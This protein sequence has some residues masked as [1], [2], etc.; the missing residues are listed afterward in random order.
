MRFRRKLVTFQVAVA[1]AIS[2]AI[3]SLIIIGQTWTIPFMTEGVASKALAC[4][5][6]WKASCRTI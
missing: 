6:I 2:V 5:R 3:G 1:V 4:A